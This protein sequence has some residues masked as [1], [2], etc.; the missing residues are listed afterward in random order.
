M[1]AKCLR[2]MVDP[3]ELA[4]STSHAPMLHV[5]GPVRLVSGQVDDWWSNYR[6]NA[7]ALT[8]TGSNCCAPDTIRYKG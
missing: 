8:L 7:G 3:I 5:Y 2:Q 4:D 6:K 1:L